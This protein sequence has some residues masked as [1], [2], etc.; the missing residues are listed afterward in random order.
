MNTSFDQIGQIVVL[1]FFIHVSLSNELSVQKFSNSNILKKD[2]P[3]SRL[4]DN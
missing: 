2:V 4:H 1:Y 3:I